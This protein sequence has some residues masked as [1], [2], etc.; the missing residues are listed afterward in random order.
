M[1]G[2]RPSLAVAPGSVPTV[3]KE[4]LSIADFEPTDIAALTAAGDPQYVDNGLVDGRLR[5]DG[6]IFNLTFTGFT[7]YY[8][9]GSVMDIPAAPN[10]AFPSFSRPTGGVVTVYR[11]HLPSGKIF[12]ITLLMSDLLAG[13]GKTAGEQEN[14]ALAAHAQFLLY[15]TLCPNIDILYT[16]AL[17]RMAFAYSGLI[18]QIWNLGLGV[19]G[20]IQIFT[21]AGALRAMAAG[22]AAA[23]LGGAARQTVGQ[24]TSQALATIGRSVL[25]TGTLTATEQ[26]TVSNIE[27]RLTSITQRAIANVNAGAATGPWAQRLAAMQSTN[28]M[29][30]LTLGNAIHEEA[31]GLARQEIQAGTLP[32]GLQSNVG[33]AIPGAGLPNS[34]GGLRP[35][36]RLP[37]SGGNEAIWDI[38]TVAQAGHAQPYTAN[39]WV[40]YVVE[41]LY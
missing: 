20:A 24:G 31:F 8:A 33:R 15:K 36:F 23:G 5:T 28:P 18:A 29:Y 3:Q 26:A 11:R 12:P 41:L 22:R 30:R 37:L 9:D 14:N 13:A 6:S 19:R 34:Y 10:S 16:N 39:A 1:I 38:T 25:K 4:D 27:T 21:T 17:L 40:Q 35:D 32:A 2:E 7:L